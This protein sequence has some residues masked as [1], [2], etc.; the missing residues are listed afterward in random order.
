[1]FL[2]IRAVVTDGIT[3]GHWRCT[4]TLAQL[5]EL[6]LADGLPP[7][8]GPCTAPLTRI[9]DRFCPK[10]QNQLGRRCLA[11]PC[12]SNALEGS[13]TCGLEA[14]KTAYK[15]FKAR[16]RSN[17]A[18]TSMLNRPGSNRPS[19]PTVH[20]HW[21]TAELVGLEDVQ[22][23]DEADRAH[24]QGREGGETPASKVCLSRSRTHNDQLIVST[25][26]I[27][28]ARETFFNSE[29]P[30]AVRVSHHS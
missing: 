29:S 11:Q 24:E 23:G 12:P 21:D 22:Q 3:I 27:V 8:N 25:C 4:A 17:F 20:Q 14:H 16:V 2:D 9:H 18:L 5:R 10:H 6:A 28:L 15:K 26:G 13:A 19:D 7:P 30:S 1:M